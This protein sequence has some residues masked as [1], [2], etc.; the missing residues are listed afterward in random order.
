MEMRMTDLI[1]PDVQNCAYLLGRARCV[2]CQYV[3]WD[4][5][6]VLWPAE[7][8]Y[9]MQR[10]WNIRRL[11][12]IYWLEIIGFAHNTT[13]KLYLVWLVCM[14]FEYEKNTTYCQYVALSMYPNLDEGIDF[15]RGIWR[16]AEIRMRMVQWYWQ[17]SALREKGPMYRRS[18]YLK[19]TSI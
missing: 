6:D 4:F 5:F 8:L 13:P 14:L 15:C 11:L 16:W 3:D 17:P 10:H 1:N 12:W 19:N 7:C 18:N 2:Y 9:N